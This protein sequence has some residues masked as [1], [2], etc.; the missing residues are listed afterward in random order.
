MRPIIINPIFNLPADIL[1]CMF[2]GLVSSKLC[3]KEI[4]LALEYYSHL[5]TFDAPSSE[6][7]ETHLSKENY[8]N[9]V[10]SDERTKDII[11]AVCGMV[12]AMAWESLKTTPIF[13]ER[14][15]LLPELKN[16]TSLN[17]LECLRN[18]ASHGGCFKF[19]NR[20]HKFFIEDEKELIWCGLRLDKD[21][22]NKKAFPDFFPAGYFAY[23]FEDIS[24]IIEKDKKGFL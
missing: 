14:G 23:L 24:M 6:T 3:D 19:I 5:V 11:N 1:T 9:I 18:A 12:A 15:E 10:N 17:Y 16:E 2:G 20:W 22:E 8:F 7:E 4:R 21:M 13:N